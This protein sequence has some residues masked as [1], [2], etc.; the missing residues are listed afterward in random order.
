MQDRD[1]DLALACALNGA[2]GSTG[3]KCTA[4]SRLVVHEAVHDAFVEKLVAGARAFKVGHALEDGTQIGPVV[5]AEQLAGN[6]DY[7]ALGKSEGAELLCGG[8][9]L[10][11][12]AEGFYMAPPSSR[13]PVTTWLS[14]ARRCSPPSPASSRSVP[15]TRR[16]QR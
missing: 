10:E 2:F 1:L 11:R 14:I 13:A 6:L 3:Q 15:M 12:P 5:S 7:V 9:R 4:S 16:W 8:E